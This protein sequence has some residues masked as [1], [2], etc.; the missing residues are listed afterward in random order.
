MAE[1]PNV[2]VVDDRAA[3]DIV[4]RGDEYASQKNP[5]RPQ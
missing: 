1:R 3:R 4:T 5:R 2:I